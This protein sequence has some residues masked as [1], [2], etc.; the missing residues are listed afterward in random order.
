MLE[1]TGERY[2]P[3]IEDAAIGYEHLHR[4][5]LAKEFVKGKKVLDL[6]SGEGYGS[7]MLAGEAESVVGIDIDPVTITHAS[8]KYIKE[9]LKFIIGSITENPIEG[10]KIF[11][12]IVCFEALEHVED[13]DKLLKE[14]KRLLKGK[15]IFIVSTPNKYYYSDQSNYQNPFHLKE[16]YFDEFKVFL[17]NN[18]KHTLIYGQKVYPSSNIFP[19]FKSRDSS[20]DFL[21]ERGFSEFLFVAPEKKLARYF[22]ALSSNSEMDESVMLGNSYLS[23]LSESL[24]RQKEGHISYLESVVREKEAEAVA[25]RAGLAEKEGVVVSLNEV[26]SQKE[27]QI[28]SLQVAIGEKEGHLGEIETAVREREGRLDSLGDAIKEREVLIDRLESAVREKEA[29]AESLRTGLAEKEGVIVSV[30]EVMSQNETQIKNLKGEIGEKNAFI[31]RL[32]SILGKRKNQI[33]ELKAD[34]RRRDSSIKERDVKNIDLQKILEDRNIFIGHLKGILGE[35]ENRVQELEAEIREKT[36]QISDKCAQVTD[37]ETK[38][39]DKENHLFSIETQL[40]RQSGLKQW[41]FISSFYAKAKTA[42]KGHQTPAPVKFNLETRLPETISLRNT[43][44][45]LVEGWIFGPSRLKRLSVWMGNRQFTSNNIEIFR[46]DVTNHYF[47]EDPAFTSM[48]SGFSVPLI[49]EPVSESQEHQVSLKAEFKK[50]H[51]FTADLGALKMEPWRPSRQELSL[52]P[53]VHGE[54]LLVICM[55]TYNPPESRFRRQVDSI[56]NQDFTNWICIVSDDCSDERCKKYMCDILKKDPRFFL[57]E[58]S[59]NVGFYHNFERALES[60]PTIAHYIALSDQDDY[61]YPNKLSECLKELVGTIQ[62]VYCD[63]RIVKENGEIVS[64]TYWKNRK[65]YYK[66]EDLDLLSIANTVTGAACVFRYGL[67][68]KVLP[69]PSR[70]GNVFHDHWIALIAAASGG[71]EYVDAPL[72]DYIQSN[73]NVIGHFDFGQVSVRKFLQRNPFMRTFRQNSRKLSFRNKLKFFLR[74]LCLMAKDFYIFGH[75]NAKHVSTIT[76]TSGI[77]NLDPRF[78][79]LVRRPLSIWGLLRMRAKISLRSETTNGI[80]LSLLF[81]RIANCVYR[82]TIPL[83]R[84]VMRRKIVRQQQNALRAAE[85]QMAAGQVLLSDEVDQGVTEF[86]RKFSGRQFNVTQKKQYVNFLLSRLDPDNFFGGYIGMFNFAKKF[87]EAGYSVRIFLTDQNQIVDSDLSRIQNHD[88]TLKSFLRRVEYRPCFS[89]GQTIDISQEDIFVA[90]SWWT[91]YIAHEGVAKTRYSKFIYIVQEYEPIFYE[92][93]AYRVL[94]EESYHLKYFPFFSTDILQKYFVESG[95]LNNGSPGKH[96][97]NPVLRF[98]VNPNL[99]EKRGDR[100]R[101]L[102]FYARPQPYNARNLY[103]LGCLAIDTARQL[104]HFPDDQWEIVGMGGDVG[105]QVLPSGARIN[106][107]GKFD[108]QKYSQLLPEH[109]IGLALMLSVHPSLVPIEMASAGLLTVTNTYNIKDENYFSM[110]SNNINAVPP[111]PE[112]IAHALIEASY[113]VHDFENRIAG[114]RIKWPHDWNEALPV[115]AIEAAMNA[116]RK[117]RR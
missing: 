76:E 62:L 93:G 48:F 40:N 68:E 106:H 53:G 82:R 114:S 116:V 77:R 66:S 111:D 57:I 19:L 71:I 61:W 49:L 24:F 1:W 31:G 25:L 75:V 26:M 3:W 37:L 105:Q 43:N 42:L 20:K 73:E 97:K 109:D 60:V 46:P 54:G 32:E 21:I 55:A 112:N 34:V 72:Y 5:R 36:L 65:N 99:Y 84:G 47:H 2:L 33:R 88:E 44:R 29:E 28:K 50:G 41:K 59:E 70:Y 63:T 79:S 115:A 102:L 74:H 45:F 56:I 83:L 35:K 95:I 89:S 14:V 13:H 69:F 104:G 100:R 27:T 86:K 113:K 51:L 18:F 6:A 101:K 12:V 78:R 108:L 4:Y 110:I 81:F 23:D 94:A 67:L 92:N 22:I 7:F 96:F 87:S 58:H 15:G 11:D 30:N 80:E 98:S 103:P 85:S 17:N 52:P 39:K 107:I 10:E 16:L 9:N 38:L 64:N 90:T 91:A 8:S 117:S